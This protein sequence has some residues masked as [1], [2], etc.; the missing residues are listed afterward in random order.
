MKSHFQNRE[1][2]WI[3]F[4][5]RVLLEATE[6]EVPDLEK[7]KFISIFISNLDEFFMVRVGSLH[8]LSSLKKEVKD[9]KTGMNAEEQIQA[10][11]KSLPKIYEEKDEIFNKVS[12][13]LEKSN[14]RQLKYK[15]LDKKQKDFVKDFYVKRIDQLVS[16]QIVD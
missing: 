2:S 15:N 9:N 16:P 6:D 11:L 3:R 4:N 14:I 12:E 13:S 5:E 1:L 8:D 7:L 10:I